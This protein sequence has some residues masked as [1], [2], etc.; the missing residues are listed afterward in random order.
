MEQILLINEIDFP[1]TSAHILMNS[2]KIFPFRTKNTAQIKDNFNIVISDLARLITGYK[3]NNKKLDEL[4]FHHFEGSNKLSE[5]I[6]NSKQL[7]FGSDEAKVDFIRFI[8]NYLF[9]DENINIV[10]T[11]LYNF[12]GGSEVNQSILRNL[13]EFI[14]DVLIAQDSEIE[15]IFKNKETDD[16]LT[17]LIIGEVDQLISSKP[18]N[19]DQGYS[20]LLPSF[21]QM[22]R[23]D[24]KFLMKYKDYFIAN[25]EMII[26]YYTFMYAIQCLRKFGKFTNGNFDEIEPLYFALEW[27]AVT[28]KRPVASSLHGYKLVKDQ[29]ADLF[30]HEYTLR[31]LSYNKFNP[32]T[33]EKEIVDYSTLYKHVES[34][35]EQYI[36][37][38]KVDLKNL[39]QTYCAWQKI[40]KIDEE[41]SDLISADEDT[42]DGL[43]NQ[44]FNLVKS[45]MHN[46]A[47]TKYGQSI[48]FLG[49]GVFLKSRG[50]LG[51]LLNVSHDFL[52]LM[53]SVIV[54]D[55]RMPFKTLLLEFE[56]RGI[57]FDRYSIEEIVDLFNNH[58]ILDKKSD[59]G[60]VQYVKPIL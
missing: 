4:S 20:D 29:A 13:A 16:I 3:L 11:Y 51:N 32:K 52:I 10:H 30:P 43:L 37:Q 48:D 27:E 33:K 41:L 58:N 55:E 46:D 45:K 14:N 34:H 44:L 60:D 36:N 54:K 38:F 22:F 19:Q 1:K 8:D 12:I 6:A 9:N 39:I 56:K 28:K 18:L 31:L 2:K 49:K 17:Q 53:T 23:N 5:F 26:N 40:V 35:G 50:N 47:K 15:E 24:L 42:V 59:S 7:Q 57:V 25:F 21:T